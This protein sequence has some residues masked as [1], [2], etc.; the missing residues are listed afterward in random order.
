MKKLVQIVGL[1]F[2]VI[3]LYT[4]CANTLEVGG[5][6]A[7]TAAVKA[8][9]AF[10]QVDMA[11][12]LAY[13]T[14]NAAFEYERENRTALWK[15]SP[16]IKHALDEIRPKAVDAKRRYALARKAYEKNPTPAGLNDLQ[17][18]LS[19]VQRLGSAAQAATIL[20]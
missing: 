8:D 2:L 5:A 9:A 12:D 14:L 18:T 16:K 3:G 4:G 10:Y 11:F 19:T 15:V 7:P 17:T 1:A 13:T 20:K 6:Y